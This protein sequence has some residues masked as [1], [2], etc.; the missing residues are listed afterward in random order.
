MDFNRAHGLLADVAYEE[1]GLLDIVCQCY[2]TVL[3]RIAFL[4]RIIVVDSDLLGSV[5]FGA[6][7]I[8]IR[9]RIHLTELYKKNYAQS[10][11]NFIFKKK[12]NLL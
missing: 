1:T 7:G 8:R 2:C 5:N 10:L 11:D 6:T 9:N 12:Q 4:P 3:T